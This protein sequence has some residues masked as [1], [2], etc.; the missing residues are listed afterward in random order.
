MYVQ[1]VDLGNE[2]R[3]R[4]QFRFA[5]APIVIRPPMANE[6]LNRRQLDA[7][8]CIRDRFARGP[9]RRLD[10]P[11]EVDERL[12]GKADVEGS[13]RGRLNRRGELSRQQADSAHSS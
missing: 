9:P 7:L 11:A 8:R 6:F 4:L 3:Q 12:L 10:A 2:V 13:Y 5:F 1:P